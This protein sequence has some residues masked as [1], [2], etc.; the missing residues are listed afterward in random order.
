[1]RVYV[2][3]SSKEVPRI[4]GIHAAIRA[5]GGDITFDWTPSI[6]R[7]IRLG[8][9]EEQLP[10]TEAKVIAETDLFTGVFGAQ[11]LLLAAPVA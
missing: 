11:V 1:M 8:I 3:G 4:R 9:S 6:E 10:D 5:L 7:A 2:A